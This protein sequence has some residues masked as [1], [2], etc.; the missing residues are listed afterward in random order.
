M[1]GDTI[2]TPIEAEYFQKRAIE[3]GDLLVWTI[4]A[5]TK[6]YPE[7]FAARPHST[8]PQPMAHK[9]VLL[10]DSLD[11]VRVMLPHGL[12][13]LAR[14]QDDDPVIIETWL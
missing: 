2:L 4:T 8:R 11:G 9:L 1:E 7:K 14:H 5:R 12:T 6:D 3:R 13:L 10:A